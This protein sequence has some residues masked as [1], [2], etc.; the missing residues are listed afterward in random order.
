ME[1]PHALKTLQLHIMINIGCT[2]LVLVLRK[3]HWRVSVTVIFNSFQQFCK[4]FRFLN[5]PRQLKPQLTKR[6][7]AQFVMVWVSSG[8]KCRL[9]I[10]FSV[11]KHDPLLTS[12]TKVLLLLGRSLNNSMQNLINKRENYTRQGLLNQMK[13]I[14]K[15]GLHKAKFP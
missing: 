14:Y 2:S 13:S 9:R 1:V 15:A 12:K 11:P 6:I 8:P 7:Q 10:R 4:F 3:M 5:P